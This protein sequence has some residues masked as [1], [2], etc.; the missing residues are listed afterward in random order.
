M[1]R[2]AQLV[3]NLTDGAEG[4][5][6]FIHALRQL[7]SAMRSRSMLLARKV[8]TRRGAIGTSTPV[9]GLRPMRSPLSRSTKVPK[10]EIFTFSL[11]AIAPH[12]SDS[13]CSTIEAES[14]RDRPISRC[15]TSLRSARVKV[16][17]PAMH[18]P[19]RLVLQNR[20]ISRTRAGRQWGL[21]IGRYQ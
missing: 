20:N 21:A 14:A 8:R 2:D 12:I 19:V 9:L 13:T 18:S 16:S 10:P 1:L 17:I 15:T 3:R 11:S 7:A 6:G 4:G 5:V